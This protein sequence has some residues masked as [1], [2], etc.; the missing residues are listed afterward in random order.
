MNPHKEDVNILELTN[1]VYFVSN[2]GTYMKDTYGITQLGMNYDR[3]MC[4][5]LT[6]CVK[7]TFLHLLGFIE[8]LKN[9]K[10][11]LNLFKQHDTTILDYI[12]EFFSTS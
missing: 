10:Q 2:L 5:D 11:M 6:D 8:K 7:D 1:F 12:S 4:E 3:P 9:V